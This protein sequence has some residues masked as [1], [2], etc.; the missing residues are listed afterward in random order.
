MNDQHQL[1]MD[2]LTA[3]RKLQAMLDS[4][5]DGTRICEA[6]DSIVIKS[7]SVAILTRPDLCDP[8]DLDDD[9]DG[10]WYDVE[11]DEWIDEEGE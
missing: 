4:E 6:V 3:A 1:A 11:D 5:T 2:I 7:H 9:D 10:G 8:D